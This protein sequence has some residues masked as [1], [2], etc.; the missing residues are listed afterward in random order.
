M[1]IPPFSPDTSGFAAVMSGTDGIG[2]IDDARGCSANYYFSEE[3][4]SDIPFRVFVSEIA[5]ED[6]II[7]SRDKLSAVFREKVELISPAFAVLCGS[8]VSTLIGTDFAEIAKHLQMESGI[9]VS[10]LP[11]SGHDAYDIGV[12]QALVVLAKLL[13]ERHESLLCTMAARSPA[14]GRRVN[15]LGPN[16]LDWNLFDLRNVS[17]RIE[18]DGMEVTAVLGGEETAENLA[19]ASMSSVNWVTTVAGVKVA[20]WMQSAFGIPYV[21]GAPFGAEVT[22]NVMNRVFGAPVKE[23]AQEAAVGQ[24]VQ[25]LIVGEQFAA[26][27]LRQT[28]LQEYGFR[29]VQVASFFQMERSLMRPGDIKLRSESDF[30]RLIDAAPT[31]VIADPLLRRCGADV[32]K[33][34]DWPHIPISA[35][36][37]SDERPSILFENA[38]TWLDKV[39]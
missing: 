36:L 15:L 3:P 39:L 11:L 22:K 12:S 4:R 13:M 34:I 25:A 1:D 26:D 35:R 6:I 14:N 38:N 19:A 8:P 37:Y 21:C 30:R 7:G 31:L 9:P 28:L 23:V 5:N 33:W 2:I 10:H 27:A 16:C 29:S 32:S 17:T 18:T 24:P 20:K